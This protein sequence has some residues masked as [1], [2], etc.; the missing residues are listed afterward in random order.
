MEPSKEIQQQ[1]QSERLSSLIRNKKFLLLW[2]ASVFSGLSFSIYFLTKSWYVV[3]ELSLKA[4]LGVVLMAMTVPRVLLMMIGGVLADRFRRSTIMFS[5]LITRSGLLFGMVILQY[6]GLINIWILIGFAFCIGILDA[7]FWPANHAIL[8]SIVS[9]DHLTRANSFLQSTNHLTLIIG[10][11]IAGWL[12]TMIA[13]EWIFGT[14]TCLLIIGAILI[15]LVKEP[16]DKPEVKRQPSPLK[17]LTEGYSYLKR[18]PVLLSLM[19]T[20][21]F[22]NFFI[23]GPGTMAIP[24]IVEERL[25]GGPLE[26]SY[27]ESTIAGGLILGAIIIG[28]INLRSKRG[29]LIITRITILGISIGLL[30]QVTFLLAG[31][32]SLGYFRYGYHYRRYTS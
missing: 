2:F 31:D 4:F 14:I 11:M 13:Y 32:F 16:F 9:K 15:Y 10:P 18:S 24:L 17:D 19:W 21:I 26:L 3:D 8:P 30:G 27:L 7:F 23:T 1:P 12:I 20:S 22:V 28:I 6:M 5:S 25:M 29:L